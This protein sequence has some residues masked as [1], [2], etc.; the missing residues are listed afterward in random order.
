MRSK[1]FRI[2]IIAVCLIAVVAEIIL[3]INVFGKRKP[4]AKAE[5][6]QK[7]DSAE[8]TATVTE[9]PEKRYTVIRM[10]SA[11]SSTGNVSYQYD[12]DGRVISIESAGALDSKSKGGVPSRRTVQTYLYDEQ[13]NVKGIEIATYDMDGN[14]LTI[15]E[16]TPVFQVLETDVYGGVA[17]K[18]DYF[19]HATAITPGMESD[20]FLFDDEERLIRICYPEGERVSEFRY[21][22]FGNVILRI[23]YDSDGSEEIR[24]CTFAYSDD[25]KMV[26]AECS[27]CGYDHTAR[28]NYRYDPAGDVV[29]EEY[30]DEDNRLL[31]EYDNFYDGAHHLTK[32]V[33]CLNGSD[34][35]VL[36]KEYEEFSVT[37]QYLTN[38]ERKELGMPYDEQV[39]VYRGS[40][41]DPYSWQ[42]WS[43]RLVVY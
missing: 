13:G 22:S 39:V 5:N 34:I 26:T 25:G 29:H 16:E 21:D 36:G 9:E 35:A 18:A 10:L 23:D 2:S 3:I 17:V 28:I 31:E 30:Y 20:L 27:D 6:G 37:E 40:I 24:R 41:V 15:R 12:E 1:T 11:R 32:R 33:R 14:L 4:E 38:E 43:D 42:L 8:E 7:A 19:E